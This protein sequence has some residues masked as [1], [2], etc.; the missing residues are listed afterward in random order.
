M[1]NF[2]MAAFKTCS[3]AASP[4]SGVSAPKPSYEKDAFS[5]GR[6]SVLT[7]T[8]VGNLAR[9][10]WR[11][12]EPEG[13]NIA[14]GGGGGQSNRD[15]GRESGNIRQGSG[16]CV[17]EGIAPGGNG[18]GCDLDSDAR[19]IYSGGSGAHRGPAGGEG[20]G[21]RRGVP[22]QGGGSAGDVGWLACPAATGWAGVSPAT[23]PGPRRAATL[24]STL[25]I[26]VDNSA[27]ESQRDGG[28]GMEGGSHTGSGGDGEGTP[29]SCGTPTTPG[30]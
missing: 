21:R 16:S 5:S 24:P 1:F 25:R 20:G 18:N 2:A 15:A 30:M 8:I 29:C 13:P 4:V 27:H 28:R 10:G 3:A 17:S 11:G 19:R 12:G 26:E 6:W 9:F 7:P 14:G 22:G 23:S